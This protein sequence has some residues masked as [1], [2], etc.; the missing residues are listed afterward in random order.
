MRTGF[1]VSLA[2]LSA[3]TAVQNVLAESGDP[4]GD[5][6]QLFNGKDLT[7]WKHVGDGAVR[8]KEGVLTTG[9]Y[10][11][12]LLYW[13]GGKVG[14]C[15]LRVVYR[16]RGDYD[17]SG[18][19][20]RIPLEPREFEM[21][22]DYG[23]LVQIENHPEVSYED[24]YHMT[25]GLYSFSKPLVKAWK[26]APEWNTLEITLDGVR[27]LVDLNGI[28]VTDF[29]EGQAVPARALEWEPERGVRPDEG[30]IALKND[31]GKRHS[32]QF[33]EVAI[34]PLP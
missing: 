31:D 3:A 19:Y 5:W 10:G 1:A 34:K 32:V 14:H 17:I 22:T 21:P 27:T 23:Y 12:G 33:K 24:E 11:T 29:V 25:G 28:R 6:R 8:V 18:I 7:G 4:T 2:L 16:T 26:P 15:K 9:G 30:W 20:I 13:T